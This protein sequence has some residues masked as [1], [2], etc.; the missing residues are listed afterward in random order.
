LKKIGKK[1]VG[2]VKSSAAQIAL[3]SAS[4][5]SNLAQQQ[6]DSA[7]SHATGQLRNLDSRIHS[8]VQRGLA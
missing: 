4:S 5:L 8:I 3:D 1:A 6:I 2:R 7:A